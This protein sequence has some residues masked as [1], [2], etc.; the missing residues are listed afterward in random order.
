[1]RFA[2]LILFML[3]AAAAANPPVASY[4]FP[5]G[6]QRGTRVDVRVGGLFLHHQCGFEML[7]PGVTAPSQ[8]KRTTTLWFEGPM[9]PLPDSQRQ[10]DYP[11]DMAG[12]IT[13]APDA[14]PGVRFWRLWTSQGATPSM[15]FMVGELPEIVENE[16]DGDPIPVK[17]TLPVTINGRIFP[18]ENIDI[19]TFQAV[20][21]QSVRCEIQAARLGSP[22]DARLEIYDDRGRKIAENDDYYGPDPVITFTPPET[23]E[24]QVRVQDTQAQGGQAYVYRLTVTAEPFVERIFPL[25][26]R[27]GGSA[28]FETFGQHVPGK[29]TVAVPGNAASDF[30]HSFTVAGKRTNSVPIDVDDLPE[31]RQPQT[32]AIAFPAMLNGRIDQPGKIDTWKWH[33]KKG[34]TWEFE[35]RAARLGSRLDAVIN[36]ADDQEK[37][38]ARAEANP[39]D[40]TLRFQVPGDG[41]YVVQI[42]DRFHSRGGPDF[43]YR[44][45]VAAPPTA[46]DF[47]LWLGGDAVTVLRNNTK[48]PARL[49]INAERLG[50]FKD[51]IPLEIPGLP[52]DV[53]FTPTTISA[54]QASADLVFKAGEG[55]KIAVHHLTIIGKARVG[56]TNVFPWPGG[57]GHVVERRARM[58]Q[59]SGTSERNAAAQTFLPAM[60]DKNFYPTDLL[61]AV[62]LPTPFVIKGEYDMGFAPRGGINRRK[63]KIERNGFEGP[64][65]VSLA[66]RQARHLQ[67]VEGPTI[68]VPAGATEFTYSAYMPPWME[69]GRTSRTCVM[70][71]G[72]IKEP[73]GSEHRVAFS[74]VNQNEQLVAVVGPGKLALDAERLSFTAQPGKSF[75]VPVRIKRGQMIEGP[76][77]LELIVPPHVKGLSASKIII[78]AKQ[79]RGGLIV[80]CAEQLRGP[81]NMPIIVRATLMHNGDP[82]VDE[83]KI[84]VQP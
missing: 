14:A 6:G 13:L 11:K 71:V 49:K 55:A 82:L 81:F 62:A 46:P 2:T 33:G 48:V 17:I 84:D 25:G 45:H 21:G 40:P 73:D 61:L 35:L 22:L 43:A 10:E 76:V 4:I 56:R 39:L 58:G 53:T 5:A 50:G 78:A 70:G 36:I 42:Q 51:P 52:K 7:G 28:E 31:F 37:V 60:A 38:L 69:T 9:L 57:T 20:K 23:G 12:Q 3:P 44:L 32:V 65:E 29:M 83:V 68:I 27:R 74:S 15:K 18:R 75:A 19:W 66:D 64:I 8:L 77:E 1:M 67:G 30:A 59:T 24:Y 41:D 72:V 34:E 79:D 54:N 47:R 63:Y 16:I 26:A 80:Q